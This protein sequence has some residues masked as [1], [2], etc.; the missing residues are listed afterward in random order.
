MVSPTWLGGA[1]KGKSGASSYAFG[2]GVFH[3]QQPQAGTERDNFDI[4]PVGAIM[5]D[6]IARHIQ[7]QVLLLGVLVADLQDNFF[8]GERFGRRCCGAYHDAKTKHTGG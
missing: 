2:V 8:L 1:D 4:D 3:K 5:L 7:R 6:Q